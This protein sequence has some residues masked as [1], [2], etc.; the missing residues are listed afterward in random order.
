MKVL[1]I[2]NYDSFTYNLVQLLHEAGAEVS[3]AKSDSFKLN[4]AEHYSHILLS[5]GPGL[6][7]DAPLMF[8]LLKRYHKKRSFLGV[9]LGHQAINEFFG[10]KLYQTTTILHGHQNWGL[11]SQQNPLFSGLP[12]KIEIGHYHSWVA[13]EPLPESL[14][15]TMRDD[16][17]HIM[18]VQH[19]SLPLYGVQFHPESVMT[20]DGKTII[21]NWL[22]NNP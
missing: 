5:P 13:A 16:N 3:I 22:A 10:G 14:K 11:I 8:E 4:I 2:D 19:K 17:N 21:K 15:V 6:P 12:G 9:C 18:A 7:K 1:L 20:P